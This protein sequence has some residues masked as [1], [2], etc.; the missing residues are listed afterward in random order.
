MSSKDSRALPKDRL[1]SLNKDGSRRFIHPAEV[2]GYFKTRRRIFYAFLVFIFLVLPWTTFNGMQTILLDLPNRKFVFFGAVF[3]AHDAPLIFFPLFIAA[4]LLTYFTAIYGRVWCG[5]AC[6]QTVFLD[7]IF[8]PV[9]KFFEGNHLKRR[10]REG[11]PLSAKEK[12]NK[13]LKWI[14]YFLICSHI[15]HS[16]IAYFVG[17]KSLVWTTLSSPLDSP[18]LFVLVQVITL[19]LC[20]DFGWFREQFCIIMCPYGRFQSVLMDEHSLAIVYDERRGEPRKQKGL[21][22]YGDCVDCFKCV[23]VCP[24]GIDIRRGVQLECISCT[25]CIDACDDVME[26]IKKPKGLISYKS[27]I[28]V[29]GGK[30]K[31]W[32][33]RSIAY[34]AMIG[35]LLT[36]FS[37]IL[38]NKKPIEYKVI[39]AVGAPFKYVSAPEGEYVLN[40]YK[41]HIFNQSQ[42]LRKVSVKLKASDY[43]L[44]SAQ[45]PSEI[46]PGENQNLYFFIKVPMDA[47]KVM[48]K[49][50]L[51]AVVTAGDFN[52]VFELKVLGEYKETK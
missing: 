46:K 44:I 13:A 14:V 27:E 49:H 34:L 52:E 31:V 25:A 40:S 45:L 5:W 26:K 36:V 29:Q 6:P 35:V 51:D 9:E 30:R 16:F 42:T 33:F 2:S 38:Y 37:F 18:A 47:F 48:S 15:S 28:E 24:T 23:S 3:N 17:A 8:R 10:K 39:R 32:N 19:A 41:L 12:L 11:K 50:S 22:D 21:K 7:F 43:E 4:L 20:F 1:S